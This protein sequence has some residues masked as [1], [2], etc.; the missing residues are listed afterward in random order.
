MC[1][2]FYVDKILHKDYFDIVQ[3]IIK[4][5]KLN[6]QLFLLSNNCITLTRKIKKILVP[7]YYYKYCSKNMVIS[8][9]EYLTNQDR[10]FIFI[11]YGENIDTYYYLNYFCDT[12]NLLTPN[13]KKYSIQVTTYENLIEKLHN[14]F[15]C[16]GY[17]L[18]SVYDNLPNTIKD[19]LHIINV[20]YGNYPVILT[21]NN[22]VYKPINIFYIFKFEIL[23]YI[24]LLLV[25]LNLLKNNQ[26]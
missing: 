20:K 10:T 22:S 1:S 17:I 11:S 14:N 19:N 5:E 9:V 2:E 26:K 25:A 23:I 18:K 6:L 4:K 3:K 16:G 12:F 24:C 8:K 13:Q 21:L 15:N 7:Y